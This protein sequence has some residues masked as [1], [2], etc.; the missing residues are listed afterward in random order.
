M[1]DTKILQKLSAQRVKDS[2]VLLKGKR[3]DTAVYLMGYALEIGFKKKI[4]HTLG[5]TNGFPDLAPDYKGYSTQI[6]TFNA[7]STGIKLNNVRDIRNHNLNNLLILS[8]AEARIKT[9]YLNEWLIVQHWNPEDRY[10]I[11]KLSLDDAN[12]F[13]QAAKKILKEIA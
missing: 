8:G 11:Q 1:I 5:F 12:S 4:C 9:H 7:I 13:I 10:K 6:A 3:H 2:M